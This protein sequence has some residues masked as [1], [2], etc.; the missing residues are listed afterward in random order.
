MSTHRRKILL[1]C[2]RIKALSPRNLPQI[3][4]KTVF[5]QSLSRGSSLSNNSKSWTEE[6]EHRQTDGKSESER[7]EDESRETQRRQPGEKNNCHDR[8]KKQVMSD[9]HADSNT[10]LQDKLLV[11]VLFGNA[12]LEFL[13]L[14]EPD[15]ELVYQLEG[16]GEE[17]EEGR[18]DGG[19]MREREREDVKKIQNQCEKFNQACLIS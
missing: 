1:I 4:C 8:M 15:E 9:L 6:K 16:G 7:K 13:T 3:L 12:G 5:R 19:R 18:R 11:Y 17:E 10:H 14:Q 2:F